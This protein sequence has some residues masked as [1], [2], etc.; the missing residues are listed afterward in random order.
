MKLVIIMVFIPQVLIISNLACAHG[1]LGSIG[2]GIGTPY[3]MQGANI[4][5]KLHDKTYLSLGLGDSENQ[6]TYGIGVHQYLLSSEHTWRPGI[7]LRYGTNGY[8]YYE[9]FRNNPDENSYWNTE[10]V[11][12]TRH[13]LGFDIVFS[14]HLAF[15]L[16][17]RHGFDFGFVCR[18][19]DGGWKK[20]FDKY[21]GSPNGPDSGCWTPFLGY[22]V[23][24]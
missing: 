21:D 14:Q 5:I 6:T 16:N 23:N 17:K 10:N 7:G 9:T 3:A 4:K 2:L 8:L 18:L 19:T 1:E 20:D 12:H 24:I 15:G 13:Y 11:E 22:R